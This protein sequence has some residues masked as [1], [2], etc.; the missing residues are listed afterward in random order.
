MPISALALKLIGGAVNA[1]AGRKAAKTLDDKAREGREQALRDGESRGYTGG[2]G[3]FRVDKDGNR[4]M[5]LNEKY[6]DQEDYFLDSADRNKG[7]LSA[8]EKG[9]PGG[10]AETLFN[11]RVGISRRNQERAEGLFDANALSRGTLGAT[12]T[13]YA[14]GQNTAGYQQ[15]E[16]QL[17]DKSYTDV[18]GIIDRY[19]SRISGDVSGAMDI[20]GSTDKYAEMARLDA[21]NRTGIARDGQEDVVDAGDGR[22]TLYKG[23][24]KGVQKGI[25]DNMDNIIPI[26]SNPGQNVGE[27]AI[28]PRDR[29]TTIAPQPTSLFGGGQRNKFRGL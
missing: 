6:Q 8:Y 26:L 21:A 9:G 23:I 7:Y 17:Y 20:A 15:A 5:E 16:N 1:Y 12:E 18:Q 2:T 10:A 27:P 28:D 14:R 19:R 24:G 13:S 22:A 25:N 11:E 29:T 3:S 4:I